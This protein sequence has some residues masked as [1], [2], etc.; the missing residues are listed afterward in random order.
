MRP[1]GNSQSSLGHGVISLERLYAFAEKHEANEDAIRLEKTALGREYSA[2]CG[3]VTRHIQDAQGFYLL[4][5]FDSRRYWHSIYL[6]KA[7]F[8]STK[9][10]K[11]RIC[12]ELKDERAFLWRAFYREGR[13]LQIRDRIHPHGKYSWYRAM[14]KRGS[15][16]VLW[17]SAPSFSS[18]G[19]TVSIGLLQINSEHA[20]DFGLTW[21]QLFDPCTNMRI[22]AHLLTAYYRQA[23]AV[24]G[25]GQQALQFA[26]SGY[27]SGFPLVGFTNGYVDSVVQGAFTAS[28]HNIE[29]HEISK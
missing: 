3:E 29:P 1:Q 23:A 28:R 11:K 24:L 18:R 16:H 27:N 19:K 15:T 9:S 2:L 4:G 5:V 12:E 10:L 13:L 26:L 7:G 22:G 14:K 25:D 21:D 6:G 8:G 17:V 20:A